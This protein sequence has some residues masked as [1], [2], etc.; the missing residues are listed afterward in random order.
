MKLKRYFVLQ[1]IF[2][3]SH[4]IYPANLPSLLQELKQDLTLLHEQLIKKSAPGLFE[5]QEAALKLLEKEKAIEKIPLYY[6]MAYAL[7]ESLDEVT[8][9]LVNAIKTSRAHPNLQFMP[10][11]EDNKKQVFR[12]SHL[13]FGDSS[14]DAGN[15]MQALMSNIKSD[16]ILVLY[17]HEN[18]AD[19]LEEFRSLAQTD[20]V[21]ITFVIERASVPEG[22]EPP[23]IL[24]DRWHDH[25]D[26]QLKK[27]IRYVGA[28][29]FAL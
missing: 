28:R 24:S 5:Q 11:T 2:L 10:L 22:I 12:D 6:T 26:S 27:L 15:T 1:V 3:L 20:N 21:F 18:E 19:Q 4:Q 25:N 17:V 13:I 9:E 29:S 8:L 23:Y 7:P 14:G 16:A